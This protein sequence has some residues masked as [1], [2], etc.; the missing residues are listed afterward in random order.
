MVVR[1]FPLL[2]VRFHLDPLSSEIVRRSTPLP[3]FLSPHARYTFRTKLV[4]K[5]GRSRG[6]V[7]LWNEDLGC[8]D[9][10]RGGNSLSC[11]G[12]DILNRVF[13]S[14]VEELTNDLDS[15]VVGDVDSGFRATGFP[16]QI[17]ST[18]AVSER[19]EKMLCDTYMRD[20]SRD[21]GRCKGDTQCDRI[22]CHDVT[23]GGRDVARVRVPPVWGVYQEPE[24][25]SG[26]PRLSLR[27]EDN[28]C[29]GKNV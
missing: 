2:V 18:Q 19:V 15:L 12:L 5:S 22:Q 29:S 10:M 6:E 16:M 24:P 7:L 17:L 26:G 1:A 21:D 13:G 3:P 23:V 28:Q 27:G 8:L 4:D 14:I 11:E 9:P 25:R 20:Q